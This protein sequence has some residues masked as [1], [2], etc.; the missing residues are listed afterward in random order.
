MDGF[1]DWVDLEP[2]ASSGEPDPLFC[3]A[4]EEC[5]AENPA[6]RRCTKMDH[7]LRSCQRSLQHIGVLRAVQQRGQIQSDEVEFRGGLWVGCGEVRS[8]TPVDAALST[9]SRTNV[10]L[11]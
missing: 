11:L 3:V 5:H 9:R 7:Y 8:S 10:A 6:F 2:A 1:K 4:L